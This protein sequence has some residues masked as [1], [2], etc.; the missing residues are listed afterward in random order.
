MGFGEWSWDQSHDGT[1]RIVVTTTS[2]PIVRSFSGGSE[3]DFPPSKVNRRRRRNTN[4]STDPHFPANVA[5]PTAAPNAGFKPGVIFALLALSTYEKVKE[6]GKV[7]HTALPA[8]Q[9]PAV[10]PCTTVC[11]PRAKEMDM[12]TKTLCY[13][14]STDSSSNLPNSSSLERYSLPELPGPVWEPL[15]LSFSPLP[16]IRSPP[17]TRA[18]ANKA[19]YQASLNQTSGKNLAPTAL[20]SPQAVGTP[21]FKILAMDMVL[22]LRSKHILLILSVR[23]PLQGNKLPLQKIRVFTG[24]LQDAVSTVE[25][26]HGQP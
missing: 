20:R 2:D 14:W 16:K 25:I 17:T 23:Q 24:C 15:L 9:P 12:G 8:D 11:R 19:G 22:D 4:R 7:K 3:E 21:Q 5:R 10:V 13:A 18:K 26:N 6:C 1:P